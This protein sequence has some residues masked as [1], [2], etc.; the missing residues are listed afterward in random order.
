[1]TPTPHTIDDFPELKPGDVLLY[2]SRS[3]V[4]WAI[5]FRT[6]S[7]VEHVEVYLGEG[8]SVASRN[9][10]GVGKYPLRIDGLVRVFRP[11][12]NPDVI[13]GLLWF[14]DVDGLPYAWT[15]LLRF[16]GWA[17]EFPDQAVTVRRVNGEVVTTDGPFAETK[18]Q[19]AGFDL[20]ECT[21]LDDAIAVAAGHPVA[22]G[23]VLDL[24]PVLV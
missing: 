24:R 5:R 13:A 12:E 23:G 10:I 9:G 2:R 4:G 8:R 17:L 14:A 11:V 18:E 21:D 3:L 6:W 1:M 7:D 15:D 22:Q 19:I 20:L 16:Y